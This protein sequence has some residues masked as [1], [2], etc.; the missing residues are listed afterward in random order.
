MDKRIVIIA[1]VVG[2]LL[3]VVAGYLVN[4]RLTELEGQVSDLDSQLARTE[5]L[6]GESQAR[7]ASAEAAAEAAQSRADSAEQRATAARVD[8]EQAAT[9]ADQ[10]EQKARLSDAD[11]E[12]AEQARAEAQAAQ[13]IAEME[14]R[15]AQD[16]AHAAIDAQEKAEEAAR[17]AREEAASIRLQRDAELNRMQQALQSFVETRRT[18][19]GMVMNLG[20]RVEFEF[21]KSELRPP[22]RELL[23]RIAG[24]LIASADQGFHIQVFGHTDDV[25]TDAYNQALS[26]RR[27]Q[28]VMDYLIEAGVDPGILSMR[29]M[30]KSMPLVAD[31][32]EEARARNRRVEI[33]VVDT[34]IEFKGGR[35]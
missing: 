8:A 15:A 27:A 35:R 5:E 18:A 34:T 32:T 21:D 25:G 22:E 13:E 20:D 6:L 7:A 4:G 33:A 14:S 17:E 3:L 28:A 9:R 26:E 11:R 29:G 12:A 19:V 1:A 31:T 23:A 16:L 30:G 10:A 2:S 24:V